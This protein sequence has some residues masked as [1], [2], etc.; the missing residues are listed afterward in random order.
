MDIKDSLDRDLRKEL[1]E[2]KQ[3]L[4]FVNHLN[5][6]MKEQVRAVQAQYK[7]LRE[8]NSELGKRQAHLKLQVQNPASCTLQSEQYSLNANIEIKTF[9]VQP[10]E[11]LNSVLGCIGEKVGETIIPS[12][13]EICHCVPIPNFSQYFDSV[14]A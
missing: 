1:H 8:E 3:S 6:K 2:I 13:I 5:K 14:S 12:D 7:S 10:S 4:I 11:N 9:P